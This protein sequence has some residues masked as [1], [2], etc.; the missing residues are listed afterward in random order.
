MN[1][2]LK[3]Q[4]CVT[5]LSILD[6]R[7][8][9]DNVSEFKALVAQLQDRSPQLVIDLSEVHYLDSPGCSALL[10][11]VRCLDRFGGQIKVCGL[12]ESARRTLD[13]FQML[14]IL[15]VYK[16]RDEAIHAFVTELAL[17]TSPGGA[18]LSVHQATAVT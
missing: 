17:W 2:Q 11:A 12:T 14:R 13:L 9:A 3:Q 8:D 16:T 1:R 4:G 15:E 6:T 7:L 18:V 5:L 10:S